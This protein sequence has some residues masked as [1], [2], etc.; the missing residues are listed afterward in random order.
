MFISVVLPAPF[1][2]SRACISPG[3]DVRSTWSLA[4]TPGNRLVTPFSS[5][6]MPILRGNPSRNEGVSQADTPSIAWQTLGLVVL[7]VDG[8]FPSMMPSFNSSS[9]LLRSAGTL[10][11]RSWN[12]AMPT[13]LFA[14]VPE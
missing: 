12:G 5:S 4:T 2:P 9:L 6:R 8:T 7:R 13:P 3:A 14:S 1:S 11:S 10:L